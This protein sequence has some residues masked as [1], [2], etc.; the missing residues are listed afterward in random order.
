MIVWPAGSN[1]MWT[2][3]DGMELRTGCDAKDWRTICDED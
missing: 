3:C 1:V 2:K